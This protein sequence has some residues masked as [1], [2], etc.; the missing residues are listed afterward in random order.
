M[1]D[2]SVRAASAAIVKTRLRARLHIATNSETLNI[3]FA[4]HMNKYKY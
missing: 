2:R 4:L 1:R 3:F